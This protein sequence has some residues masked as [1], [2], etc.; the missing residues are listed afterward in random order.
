KVKVREQKRAEGE[1]RILDSTVGRFVPLLSVAPA[2]AESELE[3]SMERLFDE[4]GSVDQVDSA[5]GGGQ[6]AEVGIA[7]GVRIVAGDNV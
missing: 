4:G 2:R 5:A 1:A 7:T 3:A 6:E